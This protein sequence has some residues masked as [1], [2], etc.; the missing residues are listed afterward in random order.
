MDLELCMFIFML[1]L[2]YIFVIA[3][4]LFNGSYWLVARRHLNVQNAQMLTP[5]ANIYTLIMEDVIKSQ[6]ILSRW[7][8]IAHSIYSDQVWAI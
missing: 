2:M 4:V 1:K 7:E 3:G 5:D 8:A 6:P